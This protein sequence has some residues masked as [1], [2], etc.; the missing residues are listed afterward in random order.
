MQW[1][2]T[3]P[4]VSTASSGKPGRRRIDGG[5][6]GGRSLKTTTMQSL[7]GVRS[8]FFRWI[9][10]DRRCGARGHGEK[11]R[12]WLWPRRRAA[13][14]SGAFGRRKRERERGG[15]R[16]RREGVRPGGSWALLARPGRRGE[17]AGRQLPWRACARHAATTRPVPL[18]RGGGRLA[19]ASQLGRPAG[20]GQ[21]AQCQ[22]AGKLPFSYFF[23]FSNF[24]TFVWFNKNTKPFYFL[25]TI[26]AGT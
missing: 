16:R 20:P 10:E 9:G 24:L 22:A 25:L 2:T 4:K 19:L 5:V 1:L 8:G 18:A 15:E 7:P 3:D 17:R 13:V 23:F 11:A 21:A 6:A 12:G 14:L 26:F